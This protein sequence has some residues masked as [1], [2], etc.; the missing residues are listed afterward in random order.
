MNVGARGISAGGGVGSHDRSKR[1]RRAKD[2]SKLVRMN[3]SGREFF[4][5]ESDLK[6]YPETLLG[7]SEKECYFQPALDCYFF[8]RNRVVFEY[9]ASFYQT[10]ALNLPTEL[11]ARLINDEL[12]FFKLNDEEMEDEESIASIPST[13]KGRMHMFLNYPSYSRE[14]AVWAGVDMCMILAGILL[15]C[16]ETEPDLK[17]HF[18]D[19][20]DAY[21]DYLWWLQTAITLFFTIDLGLRAATWPQISTFF[22]E[23]INVLDF[24]SIIPFYIQY[25]LDALH[26]GE[27]GILISVG[28]LFRMIRVIRVVKFFRYFKEMFLII[29]FIAQA[30][31]EIVL[32]ICLTSMLLVIFGSILYNVENEKNGKQFYSI[33]QVNIYYV[34][35]L[36]WYSTSLSVAKVFILSSTFLTTSSSSRVSGGL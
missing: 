15:Y 21:Y 23:P 4:I 35:K 31:K 7:S 20:A 1:R 13:L 25:L 19:P 33:A 30:W 11:D 2:C 14:S 8:D 6:L 32:I 17:Q 3:V 16:L 5:H 22:Q 28:R 26:V 12:T 9:I 34:S 24:I 10:G 36:M 29:Q 18:T 27:S